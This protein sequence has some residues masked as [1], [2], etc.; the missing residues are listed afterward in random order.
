LAGD[1]TRVALAD[2]VTVLFAG[3]LAAAIV[4]LGS[5]P[6]VPS[7]PVFAVL[8][9]GATV[10]YLFLADLAALAGALA[11][12]AGAAFLAA[13][14]AFRAALNGE[15]GA[16]RTLLEAAI[17]TGAPVCGLRP[18]LA[19][20]E[21]GVKTP[22]PSNDTLSPLFTVEM[23]PSSTASTAD[24]AAF[25]SSDDADATWSMSSDLFTPPP[26]RSRGSSPNQR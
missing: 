3:V 9:R 1:P 20:R 14:L 19:A 12:L 15:P 6:T 10:A 24:V 26:W 5:V 21:V 16:K 4:L 17:F 2:A 13:P 11:A 23:M 7:F 8:D 25:F 18:V 22:N